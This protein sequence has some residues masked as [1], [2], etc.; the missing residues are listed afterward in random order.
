MQEGSWELEA[1][2]LAA[3]LGSGLWPCVGGGGSSWRSEAQ[4]LLWRLSFFLIVW[5]SETV[6]PYDLGDWTPLAL[7]LLL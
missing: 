4:W 3:G 6:K 5:S 7:S 2:I 1:V